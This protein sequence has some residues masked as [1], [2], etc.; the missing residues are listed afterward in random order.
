MRPA[1]ALF[2]LMLSGLR[3]DAIGQASIA[4]IS[5][6]KT[7]LMGGGEEAAAWGTCLALGFSQEEKE[8][9]RFDSHSPRLI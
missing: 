1:A 4:S 2:I 9:Y 3:G 8:Q 5:S 6:Q 7:G